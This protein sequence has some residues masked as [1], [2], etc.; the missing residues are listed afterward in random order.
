MKIFRSSSLGV[1]LIQFLS[2]IIGLIGIF[3][4]PIGYAELLSIFI[5]YFLYCGVGIGLM[6]HRYF[7][8]KVFEFKNRILKFCFIMISILAGRGSPI[9]WV[10]VHRE[11]HG[12]SDTEKDPHSPRYKKFKIFFP[13][14]LSLGENFNI[15]LV[16]DLLTK[17]H[18]LINNFYFLINLIYAVILYAIDPWF[19]I[20]IWAVPIALTAWMMSLSTYFNHTHGYQNFNTNDDS[21][22]NWF[23][24]YFMFGEGWHNNHHKHPTALVNTVRSWEFDLIGK[25]VLVL[26]KLSLVKLNKR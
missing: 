10:H 14:L 17:E 9:G 16:K 5:F 24:G 18:R 23:F 8:H 20:F 7:S 21:K 6:Y 3:Y 25:L 4:F 1:S 12:F 19:L 11:H 15:R 22:N 2:S 26:E 13:H